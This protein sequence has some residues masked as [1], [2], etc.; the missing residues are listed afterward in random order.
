[1]NIANKL[2]IARF[3]I[4]PL[5]LVVISIDFEFCWIGFFPVSADLD[6]WR[7][8]VYLCFYRVDLVSLYP[9]LFKDLED[10]DLCIRSMYKS[11]NF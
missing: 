6:R 3:V 5:M 2:T 9:Y 11:L 4:I 10:P 8:Y 7:I 1:M